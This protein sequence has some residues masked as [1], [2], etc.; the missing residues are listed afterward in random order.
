[1]SERTKFLF[2]VSF[3]EQVPASGL[4][5]EPAVS[6][7]DVEAARLAGYQDGEQAGRA[8]A[9]AELQ[10]VGAE[11]LDL[12]S[13]QLEDSFSQLQNLIAAQERDAVDI[14]V[15]VGRRL[16]ER[17]VDRHPLA[18]IQGLVMNCLRELRQEPRLVLRTSER[19]ADQ[20]R[21]DIDDLARNC[22]FEG[23]VVLLPQDDLSDQDCRIEWADGAAERDAA[24]TE[25]EINN[26]VAR[27]MD[28]RSDA[29]TQAE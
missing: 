15:H 4:E 17:L 13:R 19:V 20:L 27:F 28:Q 26:A 7:E 3:D 23:R 5:K 29:A 9:M 22:G 14:G 18:E 16:A 8:A 24:R 11:A 21:Q 10:A 1:M 2:D 12:I 6:A 25:Q